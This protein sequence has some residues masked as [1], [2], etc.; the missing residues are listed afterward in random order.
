[1]NAPSPADRQRAE[2][3]SQ[4][5][6]AARAPLSAARRQSDESAK[7]SLVG[8]P[9]RLQL[10]GTR[11]SMGDPGGGVMRHCVWSV[12]QG[13]V[14][15]KRS[16]YCRPDV[17]S[18]EIST[19]TSPGTLSS[20]PKGASRPPS[21]VRIQPPDARD[22]GQVDPLQGRRKFTV[23]HHLANA[24]PPWA[25]FSLRC[26]APRRFTTPW[27]TPRIIA[28][29]RSLSPDVIL[30]S[31]PPPYKRAAPARS[32]T[33]RSARRRLPPRPWRS[34]NPIPPEKHSRSAGQRWSAPAPAP[35]H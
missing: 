3:S 31:P 21:S 32:A 19:L 9:C 8:L 20:M 27:R 11:L 22:F 23:K 2:P 26:I 6:R 12:H 1:M 7:P 17:P 13:T 14:R 24:R 34:A 5:G 10:T 18:F 28:Q 25:V 15:P 35:A 33:T 4:N 16:R 30:Q 29:Q